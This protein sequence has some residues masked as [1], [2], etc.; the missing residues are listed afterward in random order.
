MRNARLR[1]LTH[2]AS[3]YMKNNR[4]V[5]MRIARLRALTHLISPTTQN[6]AF[7]VEMRIARLRALTQLL[8]LLLLY[9]MVCRNED[10]PS[11]GIDTQ[12]SGSSNRTFVCFQN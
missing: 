11:E 7:R 1:A 9:L 8:V 10:C 6:R 12:K 4:W 3:F 2:P 5:E